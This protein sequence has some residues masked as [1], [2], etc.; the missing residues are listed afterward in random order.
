M[1][2]S[3]V[4]DDFLEADGNVNCTKYLEILSKGKETMFCKA[5]SSACPRY[6]GF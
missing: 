3:R 2:F 6:C 4:A 5:Y 1:C